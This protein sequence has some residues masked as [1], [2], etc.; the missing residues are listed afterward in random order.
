M[1]PIILN[2]QDLHISSSLFTIPPFHLLFT[3]FVIGPLSLKYYGLAY[4]T[5][6]LLGWWLARRLA[7]LPP[8]AATAQQV[9]DFLTWAVLGVLLGGRIGYLLFYQLYQESLG[10]LLTHPIDIIAVWRGGMSSH[11]GFIGV[12]IAI[13]WFCQKNDI[14]MLRFADRISV[15][16]P[17]GLCLGRCANFINGELWGRVAEANWFPLLIIYPESG[18]NLPRYPS[19]LIEAATEGALLFLVMILAVRSD[20]LRQRAGLLTGIFLI[21]YSIARIF[22][23]CFRQPDTFLNF[24]AFGTTRGQILSLP[25]LAA[26][27]GLAAYATWRAPRA[28]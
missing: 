23:E 21:L 3:G 11:G 1:S 14:N 19:E 18:S 25:L 10:Q 28:A 7:A 17:I 27:L 26:G 15:C 8:V 9:D 20:A 6:L 4:M 16:V 13:I 22:S 2:F 24:L 5:G 12:S